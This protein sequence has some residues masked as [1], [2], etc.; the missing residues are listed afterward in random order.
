M[1]IGTSTFIQ[2]IPALLI[3]ERISYKRKSDCDTVF[4]VNK[5]QHDSQIIKQNN[6]TFCNKVADS[7]SDM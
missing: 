3:F 1:L 2:P 6:K 4:D 5:Q 7:Q